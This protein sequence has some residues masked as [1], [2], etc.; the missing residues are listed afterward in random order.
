MRV[1]VLLVVLSCGGPD[2]RARDP[3]PPLEL[4]ETSAGGSTGDGPR[5][6]LPAWPD[7]PSADSSGGGT[8]TGAEDST[9][10]SSGSTST[11]SGSS[12]GGGTSTGEAA[13]T[14]GSSSGE[15]ST[16]QGPVPSGCPCAPGI[17]NFCD[18]A[19]GTCPPTLPGGYCDP[20]GDGAYFD[21]DF[22]AGFLGW[23]AECT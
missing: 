14:G 7:L 22:N 8:S 23:K 13:S 17:D 10:G 9:S 4:P 18:L 5:L 15:A 20:D 6:D 3:H 16:G 12:S 11:G 21:A 1:S 19:P 2:G